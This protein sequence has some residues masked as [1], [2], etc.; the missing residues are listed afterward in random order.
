M[1]ICFTIYWIDWRKLNIFKFLQPLFFVEMRLVL[2]FDFQVSPEA[3][4]ASVL[5]SNA[6]EM[7]GV[8]AAEGINNYGIKLVQI[9]SS[10]S[11]FN[12]LRLGDIYVKELAHHWI[13]EWLVTY[14]AQT[15]YLNQS[16]LIVNHTLRKK[17]QCDS[18]HN[19]MTFLQENPF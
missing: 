15:H 13:R 7:Q 18:N 9:V 1:L 19:I 2:Y 17:L 8:R 11:L 4:I 3:Y 6:L 5:H 16:W 12:P 10:V 14:V